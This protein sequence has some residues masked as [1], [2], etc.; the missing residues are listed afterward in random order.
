MGGGG[1][2]SADIFLTKVEGFLQVRM[3]ALFGTINFKF[4]KI[5]GVYA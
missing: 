4:F 2:S 3:S 5:Y 1:L